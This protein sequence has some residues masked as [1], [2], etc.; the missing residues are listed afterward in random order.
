M[1]VLLLLLVATLGL[2]SARKSSKRSS[3]TSSAAQPTRDDTAYDELPFDGIEIGSPDGDDHGWLRYKSVPVLESLACTLERRAGLTVEEFEQEYRHKKKPVVFA[4]GLLQSWRA[5]TSW[6]KP[7]LLLKYGNA[8][9]KMGSSAELVFSAG[10]DSVRPV[11]LAEAIER[12]ARDPGLLMFD[13]E[14]LIRQA[15][16]ILQDF[17]PPP[18]V[19]AFSPADRQAT[20]AGA[21]AG[22]DS[23]NMISMGGPGSGLPWH[24]HG[25][26]WIAAVFG[27]K[28]WFVYPPGAAGSAERGN[29]LDDAAAWLARTFNGL[30][31]AR[32]PQH[33]VQQAGEIVYLP[34]GE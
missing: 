31:L 18:H 25:E 22:A 29:P 32:R 15:P 6:Q 30:P 28:A 34:A 16:S 1:Y 12:R 3:S 9:A 11:A 27:R 17:S 33:C 20:L 4:P 26:T 24:T 19:Q 21:G 5:Q 2:S 8:T 13:N 10:D 7:N 14:W 23:W